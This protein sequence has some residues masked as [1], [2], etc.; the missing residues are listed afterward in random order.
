MVSRPPPPARADHVPPLDATDP[1]VQ[2][3]VRL[4]RSLVET[5]DLRRA[6]LGL[7]RDEWVRRALT[8]ALTTPPGSPASIQSANGRRTT[9]SPM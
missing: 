1:R 3:N 2:M 6:A 9:R 5:C 7:T 8:F 4:P